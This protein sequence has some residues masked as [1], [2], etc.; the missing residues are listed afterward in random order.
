MYVHCMYSYVRTLYVRLC[1][2]IVH[3][4]PYVQK[5]FISNVTY[6]ICMWGLVRTMYVHCTYIGPLGTTTF[7]HWNV[8]TWA[9]LPCLFQVDMGRMMK[10]SRI[11]TQ[12]DGYSYYIK[13]YRLLYSTT[14][15]GF[16]AYA[17]KNSTIRVCKPLKRSLHENLSSHLIL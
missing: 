8:S 16:Y 4:D 5:T 7:V 2:Y 17:F 14:G 6:Q 9:N 13:T 11:E 10:V 1:T 3:R 12:G 15:L